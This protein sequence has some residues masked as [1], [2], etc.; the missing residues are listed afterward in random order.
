MR[1]R[2]P[3]SP[4]RFGE[5]PSIYPTD[6]VFKRLTIDRSWPQEQMREIGRAWSRI[7]TQASQDAEKEKLE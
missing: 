6:E 1:P 4:R 3:T 2:C 5:D 7:K